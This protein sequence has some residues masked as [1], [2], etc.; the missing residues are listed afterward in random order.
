MNA[1]GQISGTI[2]LHPRIFSLSGPIHAL[3]NESDHFFFYS[4]WFAH[5]LKL[6]MMT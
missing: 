2:I 6:H 1:R 3:E 5:S 4:S